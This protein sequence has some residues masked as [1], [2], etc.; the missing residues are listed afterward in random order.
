MGP[1][2]EAGHS[3]RPGLTAALRPPWAPGPGLTPARG[4]PPVSVS[5]LS[6]W[7]LVYKMRP[8]FKRK[9]HL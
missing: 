5:G 1:R 4:W 2:K 9:G 6:G 3:G 8:G 7:W